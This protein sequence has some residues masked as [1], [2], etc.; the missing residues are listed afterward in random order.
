MVTRIAASAADRE[1]LQSL[2]I[3][4]STQQDDFFDYSK[5]VIKK[6]WGHEYVI[7]KND[8]V[9][10]WVLHIKHGF[11][12]SMHCH[13]NKKTSIA[14]LSGE[15][16]FNTL[17]N[18][19]RLRPGEG[20]FLDRGVFH[21]TRAVSP[22]GILVMETETPTNK[23]DLVRLSDSYGR[24]GQ[25]YE[26][27]EHYLDFADSELNHFHKPEE[28]YL[29]EKQFGECALTVT[30][31]HDTEDLKA[32]LAHIGGNIAAI[33]SGGLLN[34]EKKCI[35]GVGDVVGVR[36]LKQ[37]GEY[38]ILKPTE[39]LLVKKLHTTNYNL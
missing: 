15:A 37:I 34:T 1:K 3:D 32:T 2:T 39:V 5:V 35:L 18:E 13:P 31:H 6:P 26:G 7:F 27:R 38:A 8:D 23:K 36:D 33:L 22:D 21:S 28:R 20:L 29:R 24:S 17:E 11:Q 4:P 10:V 16:A 19:H 25:G 12:T 14:A 30:Q 9:A